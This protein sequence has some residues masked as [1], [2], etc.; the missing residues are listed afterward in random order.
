LVAVTA[1]AC[2]SAL[3]EE[4]RAVAAE[5]AML[6]TERMVTAD[7][8]AKLAEQLNSKTK[9][10]QQAD[11]K[12]QELMGDLRDASDHIAELRQQLQQTVEALDA[13]RY[14]NHYYVGCTVLEYHT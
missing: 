1:E 9:L 3:A 7:Y 13:Q 6:H 2:N 12:Y 10:L 4:N 14:F 8:C 5:N 11:E